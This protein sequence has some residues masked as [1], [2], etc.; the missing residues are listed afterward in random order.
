MVFGHNARTRPPFHAAAIGLIHPDAVDE[1]RRE[2]GEE[3][4]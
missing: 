4:G 2:A 1:V 3:P